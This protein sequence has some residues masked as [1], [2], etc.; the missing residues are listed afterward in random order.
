[1]QRQAANVVPSDGSAPLAS[2]PV[3]SAPIT[4]FSTSM[5]NETLQRIVSTI[6]QVVLTSIN[7]AGSTHTPP[8]RSAT[9]TTELVE[10]P[11][12]E[13]GSDQVNSASAFALVASA[14][15]M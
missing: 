8:P 12:V 14:L 15:I 5:N 3:V 4:T 6:L 1:M 11:M 7:G 10:V 13:S 2:T 9:A